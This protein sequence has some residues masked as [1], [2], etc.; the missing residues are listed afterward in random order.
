M[1]V[2]NRKVEDGLVGATPK[3][4]AGE[5]NNRTLKDMFYVASGNDLQMPS[6]LDSRTFLPREVSLI[7]KQ[8][9]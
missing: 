7:M 6:G 2:I 5:P 1:L 4:E 9:P 8:N 3:T